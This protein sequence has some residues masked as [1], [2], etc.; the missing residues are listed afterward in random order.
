MRADLDRADW[1]AMGTPIAPFPPVSVLTR[2]LPA[3]PEAAR[4][5]PTAALE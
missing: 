5:M 2:G 1:C 3:A 4:T